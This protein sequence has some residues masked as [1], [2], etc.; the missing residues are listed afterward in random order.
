MIR[1]RPE[2]DTLNPPGQIVNR[3]HHDHVNP[4]GS[5]MAPNNYVPDAITE[6][7][8]KEWKKWE[9]QR[10]TPV[11]YAVCDVCS[12]TD[13]CKMREAERKATAT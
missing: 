10:N 2:K 3:P 4:D 1:K 7:N 8:M 11:R 5:E 6:H 12:C 13:V 9:Q